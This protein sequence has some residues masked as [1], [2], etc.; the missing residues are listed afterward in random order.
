MTL[1]EFLRE[2]EKLCELFHD[3]NHLV[4]IAALAEAGKELPL[5]LRIIRAILAEIEDE[6]V[7]D[8]KVVWI[9]ERILKETQT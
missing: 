8:R 3:P 7:L 4:Q 6:E 1:E 5:A 2:N 9:C